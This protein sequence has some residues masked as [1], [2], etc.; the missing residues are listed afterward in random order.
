MYFIYCE[1]VCYIAVIGTFMVQFD[2]DKNTTLYKNKLVTFI[3]GSTFYI[4]YLLE[5]LW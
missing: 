2:F 3:R 5:G 4:Y 1:T